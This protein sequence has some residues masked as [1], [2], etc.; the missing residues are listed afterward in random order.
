MGRAVHNHGTLDRDSGVRTRSIRAEAH[1]VRNDAAEKHRRA[2]RYDRPL[3]NL[4]GYDYASRL[5]RRR[6]RS[7]GVRDDERR[8]DG[9]AARG[10]RFRNRADLLLSVSQC[11]GTRSENARAA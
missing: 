6:N 5:H 7:D 4:A 3:E 2:E 10:R 1:Q 9:Y 8:L 11:V